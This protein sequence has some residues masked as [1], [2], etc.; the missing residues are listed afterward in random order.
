MIENYEW[1]K[2][3]RTT[4]EIAENLK[5]L[6]KVNANAVGN[7]DEYF[8]YVVDRL[9]M[10]LGN[11]KKIEAYMKLDSNLKPVSVADGNNKKT[12][13]RDCFVNYNGFDLVVEATMRPL[14][15]TALHWTH[16]EKNN[17]IPQFGIIVIPD[18]TK[19]NVNLWNDNKRRIDEKDE[20]FHLCDADFLFKLLKDQPTAFTKF[21][22]FLTE[23]ERIWR[24]EKDYE[25]IQQKV[26]T[27]VKP[28]N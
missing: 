6:R 19:I 3:Q 13:G 16:L 14:S 25:T 12:L 15:H 18:I 24:E 5:C 1:I 7:V 2:K 23:S 10:A 9:F 28:E 11:Y 4:L 17:A 21:Q 26:I 20:F 8:E 27:L 22:G